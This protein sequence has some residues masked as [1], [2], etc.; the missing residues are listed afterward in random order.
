MTNVTVG[1]KTFIPL[2]NYATTYTANAASANAAVAQAQ[3]GTI[4]IQKLLTAREDMAKLA[5][6]SQE[7]LTAA[8]E[9]ERA[10]LE[11]QKGA[12]LVAGAAEEQLP[13]R[14]ARQFQK[15]GD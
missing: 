15:V 10:I 12:E 4:V 7:T 2:P 6:G 5:Q 3:N 14:A 13:Q 11:A 8:I 9:A 1:D